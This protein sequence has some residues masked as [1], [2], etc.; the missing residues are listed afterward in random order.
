M[1]QLSDLKINNIK[2]QE[3]FENI[4]DKY[5]IRIF[6]ATKFLIK[7]I[8]ASR[9][10]NA[11]YVEKGFGGHFNKKGNFLIAKWIDSLIS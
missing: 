2:R 1:P 8:G 7:E 11:L 6:D 4:R 3:F 5:N 9:D 10:A